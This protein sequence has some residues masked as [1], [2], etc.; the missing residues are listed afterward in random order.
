[1]GIAP[2]GQ[3]ATTRFAFLAESPYAGIVSDAH[4]APPAWSEALN[5]L[6]N[7]ARCLAALRTSP[8]GS[9]RATLLRACTVDCLRF[10]LVCAMN[11]HALAPRRPFLIRS[12]FLS[13]STQHE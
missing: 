1:M 8:A 9:A 3:I 2:A 11:R 12:I 13:G 5:V 7:F 4:A 6:A 10:P